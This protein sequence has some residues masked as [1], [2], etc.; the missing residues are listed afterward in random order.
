MDK[1]HGVQG[2]H[3]KYTICYARVDRADQEQE[4]DVQIQSMMKKYQDVVVLTDI[5]SGF[6]RD[7][8]GY[9][10]LLQFMKRGD[11]AEIIVTSMDRIYNNTIHIL[12]E[13]LGVKLVVLSQ[14]ISMDVDEWIETTVSAT[15]ASSTA[16][17]NR[18]EPKKSK[19]RKKRAT[20]EEIADRA[21]IFNETIGQFIDE[22]LESG[23]DYSIDQ[24]ALMRIFKEFASQRGFK[25]TKQTVVGRFNKIFTKVG[26]HYVCVR[27]KQDFEVG[28]LVK[29]FTDK[30]LVKNTGH[31]TDRALLLE[32]FKEFSTKNGVRNVDSKLASDKFDEMFSLNGKTYIGVMNTHELAQLGRYNII[33]DGFI[34]ELLEVGEQYAIDQN[35]LVRMFKEFTL[36]NDVKF[37]SKLAIKIFDEKFQKIDKK[38]LGIQCKEL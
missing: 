18:S 10:A 21:R 16:I 26:M 38:Y 3:M 35:S 25:Y 5:G 12:L 24:E 6:G 15:G 30:Y 33:I 20:K 36:N 8:G 32:S 1:R 2:A 17:S 11:V 4:L 37:N 19:E 27:N 28:W 31:T 7:M 34:H 13:V 29:Q 23:P 9:N 22:R 14:L